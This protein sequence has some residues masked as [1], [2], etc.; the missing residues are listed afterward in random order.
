MRTITITAEEQR[1]LLELIETGNVCKVSCYY[2]YKTDMC[3][4]CKLKSKIWDLHDKIEGVK[5]C[6]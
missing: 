5:P 1:L 3:S 6:R 2:E 4:K